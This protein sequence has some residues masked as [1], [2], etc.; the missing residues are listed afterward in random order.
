M[1]V[2][3][4]NTMWLAH[5]VDANNA[6]SIMEAKVAFK[7]V[8]YTFCALFVIEICIRF[9]AFDRKQNAVTDAWFC[10]DAFLVLLMVLEICLIPFVM[11][12]VGT[13]GRISGFSVFRV[14]RLL[15]IARM[16]RLLRAIPVVLILLKGIIAAFKSVFFTL[17]LLAVFV[18]VFAIIF[19]SQSASMTPQLEK[20]YFKSVGGAM[21]TLLLHGTFLDNVTDA[22]TLLKS[23]GGTWL[24]TVFVIFIFISN[25]TVLNML[26][27]IVCQVVSE[28]K[29]K[30]D[31][32][33]ETAFLKY[34]LLDILE[35]YDKTGDKLINKA[36]F[37]MLM[38]NTDVREVLSKFGTDVKG[39]QT[40][41]DVLFDSSTVESESGCL[42][43]K[44]F[45]GVIL[46]LRNGH[47]ARVT[48]VVDLREYTR[49]RLDLVEDMIK[50]Q[51]GALSRKIEHVEPVPS[52][53]RQ[54]ILVNVEMDKQH[55]VQWHVSTLTIAEL[56]EQLHAD[57][58]RYIALD[59]DGIELGRK[60][61]IGN[62]THE[63]NATI[64]IRVV[65]KYG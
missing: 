12:V 3:V 42:S 64:N 58:Q 54:L 61:T 11:T 47:T 56:L 14:L 31:E 22:L 7:V 57:S 20:T 50:Q 24:T 17:V 4:L 28:V 13:T 45:L 25:C 27:G 60:L 35:C 5:D 8:E 23:D 32:K 15:R 10:L 39:L 65:P 63:P 30:E 29:E 2:V 26:I 21:W 38:N 51:I 16:T 34:N 1:L 36:E 46:R 53:Q 6:D 41:A 59:K 9:F 37:K 49:H 33:A 55:R 40:L 43:F 52:M 44:E 19:R 18:Y 62:I 48:D